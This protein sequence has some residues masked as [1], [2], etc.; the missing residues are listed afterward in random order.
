MFNV[1]LSSTWT[2]E[3]GL[4]RSAAVNKV[5]YPEGNQIALQARGLLSNLYL[6]AQLYEYLIERIIN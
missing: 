1:C 4:I 5:T 3:S 6:A 2:A